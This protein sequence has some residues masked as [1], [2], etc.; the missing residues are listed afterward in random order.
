VRKTTG[1]GFA[2]VLL[3]IPF[4][5]V[6]FGLYLVLMLAASTAGGLL[7]GR[8]SAI[9]VALGTLSAFGLLKAW[10]DVYVFKIK[11]GTH[12]ELFVLVALNLALALVCASAT[13]AGVRVRKSNGS[14]I[15]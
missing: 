5:P 4:T 1:I 9:Y 11:P 3:L 14:G 7:I 10:G 12:P 13:A 8:R 15:G 2:A 6:S